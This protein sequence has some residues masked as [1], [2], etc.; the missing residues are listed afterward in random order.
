[1]S[2]VACLCVCVSLSQSN[3]ISV[4]WTHWW[5]VQTPLN[6]SRCRL[7]QGQIRVGPRNF[8]L[9]WLH[10]LQENFWVRHVPAPWIIP[11]GNFL[12]SSAAGAAHC[13]PAIQRTSAFAAT[14]GDYRRV[15]PAMRPCA[16]LLRRSRHRAYTLNISAHPRIVCGEFSIY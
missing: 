5:A 6:P 2:H 14:R 7:G 1:M 13:S 9:Y 8:V 3:S 12:H 15:N 10:I 11:P 4:C 16:E